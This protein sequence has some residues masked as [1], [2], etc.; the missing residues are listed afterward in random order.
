MNLI[1]SEEDYHKVYRD[2]YC[3]SNLTQLNAFRDSTCLFIG[4]SLTDPN[5]R[6]LLDIAAQNSE[7][8]RH[9]AILMRQSYDLSSI[10]GSI[11]S[12]TVDLYERIDNNI[13]ENFFESIGLNIIWIDKYEEIPKILSALR[14]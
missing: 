6:R 7:S 1:F 10:E 3:W 12:T 11:N 4:C 8:P 5:V 9:Y 14:K 2:A 13:R